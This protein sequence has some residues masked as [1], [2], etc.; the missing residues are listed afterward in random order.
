M[1]ATIQSEDYERYFVE[2]TA[3]SKYL[4]EVYV[5]EPEK[6]DL[7]IMLDSHLKL[8][9]KK[10]KVKP[11]QEAVKFGIYTSSLSESPSYE[12]GNVISIFE[13]AFREA[14]RKGKKYVDKECIL[15][16]YNADLK[17]YENI[18][19]KEKRATAYHETGHYIL[20]VMCENRR[21][22]KISCVSILPMMWWAGVTMSYFDRK[23]YVIRSREYFI[24]QIAMSLAGRVAERRIIET[25]STGASNDL[26]YVNTY[27]KAVVM[28][29]GLSDKENNQNR[30]Y[31]YE[32]YFL[33]PES[34]KELI[35]KEIQELIDAGMERAEKII[36][37][38]E[39]LV[40]VIAERL[41]VDE[42]LTGEELE[43]ICKEYKEGKD[44][45]SE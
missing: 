7:R 36:S 17:D 38:N 1:I 15:S 34:K 40:K 20:Q 35:D 12:P 14:R 3:I 19:E 21:D 9:E 5:E 16:C 33:M 4:N 45:V 37:D 25:N 23:E 29:W 31:D 10:Y 41:M 8:F 44:K 39:G 6:D 43:Q 42:I 13:K 18:P 2:D 32:D 11:T 27:A 26:E 28:K 22:F 24:E 30:S